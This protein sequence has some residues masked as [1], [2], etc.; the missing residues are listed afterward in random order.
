MKNTPWLRFMGMVLTAGFLSCGCTGYSLP[1]LTQ[2]RPYSLI[3][4]GD[5]YGRDQIANRWLVAEKKFPV[6]GK[7][8]NE[9]TS[10]LGQPQQVEVLEHN[11]SEDWYFIYYKNYKL[12]PS[13]PEGTFMVRFYHDAVIDVVKLD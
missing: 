9:M 10:L 2:I 1:P 6:K 4:G 3:S 11:V 7:D 8:K 5:Q 12:A 13:T